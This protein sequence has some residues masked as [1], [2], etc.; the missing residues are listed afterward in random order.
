[1]DKDKRERLE[2]AGWQFGSADEFLGNP[3]D[4]F[5]NWFLYLKQLARERYGFPQESV[6]NFNAEVFK[7]I[8]FDKGSTPEE[9]MM[10]ELA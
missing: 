5:T 3:V 2:K 8:Y 9:A 4:D 7:E 1:M 10:E 6:N